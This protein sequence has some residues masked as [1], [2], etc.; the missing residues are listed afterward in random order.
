MP[1]QTDKK[2][3]WREVKK[4]KSKPIK[5][6]IIDSRKSFRQIL[7][8]TL[9][10]RR[11]KAFIT[12]MFMIYTPIL[13]ITTYVILGSAQDF[14]EDQI[15]IFLCLVVYAGIYALFIAISG[16]TPGLKY[17][18]IKLTRT[19]GDKVGFFRAFVRVFIWAIGVA[20]LIGIISPFFL[21]SRKF[22]WDVCADTI[23]I[24]Q[25]KL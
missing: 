5:K 9:A 18:Q 13:Y 16:Q 24:D 23:I 1:K 25:T 22:L 12:D 3:R 17:A 15:A 8:E 10:F 14:K 11:L 21:K 19:N 6:S 20:L 4:S 7:D 2:T